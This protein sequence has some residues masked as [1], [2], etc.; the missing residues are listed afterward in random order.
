M[1]DKERQQLRDELEKENA[2]KGTPM[3]SFTHN[4]VK[5]G[6]HR[7]PFSDP[8]NVMVIV[9]GSGAG[10]SIIFQTIAGSTAPGAEDVDE[11]R[12]YMN[13]VIRGATFTKYGR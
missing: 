1:T 5:P 2:G 8:A 4:D 7:E 12:P 6:M 9:A 3:Y 10:N 11:P 13:K